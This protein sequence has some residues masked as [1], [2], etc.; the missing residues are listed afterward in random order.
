MLIL[1]INDSLFEAGVSVAVLSKLEKNPYL[2]CY[3]L[4]TLIQFSVSIPFWPKVM[5]TS[6]HT[7]LI[8]WQVALLSVIHREEILKKKKKK[9]EFVGTLPQK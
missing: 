2:F 5:L 9:K 4:P 7:D 1:P 8:C 6:E 3:V